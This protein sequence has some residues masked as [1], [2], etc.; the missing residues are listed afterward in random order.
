MTSP[1]EPTPVVPVIATTSARRGR[2]P[3]DLLLVGAAV[4]A[5]GGV[6]FAVGRMTAPPATAAFPGGG[7]FTPGGVV[8]GASL[9]PGQSPGAGGPG[10]GGPGAGG[11][12]AGGPGGF[13]LGG[14]SMTGTVTSVDAD[15]LTLT[16]ESGEEVTIALDDATDY[17][18]A[19]DATA[20]DISVG[21]TV[22]VGVGLDGLA[23][24]GAGDAPA[25]TADDV[26]VVP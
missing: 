8:P 19:D 4:L 3:L 16:L 24:G 12:G 13:N 20:A 17:W 18:T 10:A 14:M 22:D 11:P 21:A 15:S 26:T 7:Q 5:I 25:F 9:A 6:A 1:N 2:N 23:P